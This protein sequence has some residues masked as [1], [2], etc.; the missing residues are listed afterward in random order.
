MIEV[1]RIVRGFEGTEE[2][3]VFQRRV[4]ATKRHDLKLFK[5]RVNLDAGKFSF[6]IAFVMTGTG[7]Q[8]RLSAWKV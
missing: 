3:N 6:G 7:C 1:F 8:G 5:K 4:G 2:V